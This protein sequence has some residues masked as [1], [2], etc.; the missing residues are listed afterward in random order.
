MCATLQSRTRRKRITNF[1]KHDT[2]RNEPNNALYMDV[3]F[4]LALLSL[5]GLMVMSI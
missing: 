1:E 3:R 4:W 5:V 2:V